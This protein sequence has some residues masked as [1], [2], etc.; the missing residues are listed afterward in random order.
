MTEKKT[1][2]RTH[3]HEHE[4]VVFSTALAEVSLLVR[5]VVCG[6][7]G[8]VDDPSEAEWSEAFHSPSKPYRWV[9]GSRVRHQRSHP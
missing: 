9:D 7:R 2:I 1:T 8:M 3:T 6:A 5:C 4:W